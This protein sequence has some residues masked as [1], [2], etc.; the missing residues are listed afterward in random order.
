MRI[1]DDVL[2]TAAGNEILTADIPRE[3]EEIER[4]VGRAARAAK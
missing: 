2:I 3:I 1:E 4:L